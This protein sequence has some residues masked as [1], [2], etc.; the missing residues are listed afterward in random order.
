MWAA[1]QA[2]TSAPPPTSAR[3]LAPAVTSGILLE[4]TSA[5]VATLVVTLEAATLVAISAAEID[6]RPRDG[7]E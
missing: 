3:I 2:A 1:E 4:A 6:R 5:V 7:A